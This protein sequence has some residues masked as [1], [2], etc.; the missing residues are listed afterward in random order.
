MRTDVTD[1]EVID[2]P[3]EEAGAHQPHVST[4]VAVVLVV[5]AVFAGL[6]IAKYQAPRV[7][8]ATD[9]QVASQSVTSVRNDAQ[10]DYE[11]ARK[12]GKP[13]YVLFHSLS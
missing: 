7:Q 2:T 5:I 9:G 6:L 1:E 10:G 8:P 12:T 13:V 11:A 4:R 3:D